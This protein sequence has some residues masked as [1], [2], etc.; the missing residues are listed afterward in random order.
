[1]KQRS[2]LVTGGSG[3]I[4]KYMINE[5]LSEGAKVYVLTHNLSSALRGVPEVRLLTGDI[6]QP[7][8]VPS[9]V[10]TIFHCAGVIT[11]ERRMHA[12]NVIGTKRIV[13]AALSHGCR[14]VHL[15]SAGVIGA[16]CHRF[17]DEF[18][19]CRPVT[20]YERTKLEAENVVM[21]GV[22]SGLQATMLR[23]TTVFGVGRAPGKDS[24]LHLLCSVK[25]GKYR[26]I[27]QGQG[28]YSIVHAREVARAMIALEQSE[29]Q[30]G[31]AY[32]INNPITFRR[33][34]EIASHAIG[35]AVPGTIP[36]PVAW[37]AT[38][39]LSLGAKVTGRKMPLTWSRL[40]ALTS[41]TIYSQEH[42]LASTEYRPAQPVESYITQ[43]CLEYVRQ[44]ML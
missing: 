2:V 37:A 5:L 13:D 29:R 31:D 8:I 28:L 17:V 40:A 24:F 19:E 32:F 14:L 35:C 27:A 10:S 6:T 34:S 42:L 30:R 26:N 33:F 18:S 20:L 43:I 1:M 39:L 44:G 12:V 7:L 16:T 21:E 41:T 4:G 3:F 36:Y 38:A 15:S 22:A 25:S 9:G 23:P 11:D